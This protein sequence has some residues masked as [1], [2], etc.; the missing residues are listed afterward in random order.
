MKYSG[1]DLHSNNRGTGS[2]AIRGFG[3]SKTVGIIADPQL[4]LQQGFQVLKNRLAVEVRRIGIL[5]QAGGP[6]NGARRADAD[7]SGP[8]ERGFRLM[9]QIGNGSQRAGIIALRGRHAPTQELT[10][11]IIQG[12]DLSFGAPEVRSHQILPQCSKWNR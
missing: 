9:H 6:G 7:R 3:E 1:I 4:A 5:E 11:F 2:G 10:A 8:P 12:D